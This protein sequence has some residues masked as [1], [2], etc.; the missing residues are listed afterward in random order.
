MEQGH[1]HKIAIGAGLATVLV[2]IATGRLPRWLRI[3]LVAG[4]AILACGAGLFGY[5]YATH[6]R[7][8]TVAAGSFDGDVPRFM[9]AIAARMAATGSPVRLNVIDKGT[10]LEA[11]KAFSAGEVD[12]AISR[13]DIGNL[14]AAETVLVITHGVVLIIAPPG[15]SITSINDLKGNTVGIVGGEV[16]HNI[17]NA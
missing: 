10:A 15:S 1:W 12:L 16:N 5:R 13:A 14:S 6:P 7:M 8:L 4:L 9:S 2:A 3:V 17:V 11:A